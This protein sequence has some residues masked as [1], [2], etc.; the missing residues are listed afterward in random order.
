MRP[1]TATSPSSNR[2][3]ALAPF[4][5][6]YP[7]AQSVVAVFR[8]ENWPAFTQPELRTAYL[9]RPCPRLAE[10]GSLYGVADLAER[11]LRV[12]LRTI[13]GQ[14]GSRQAVDE[15][16]IGLNAALFLGTY[17][18]RC[19]L[20]DMMLYFAGFNSEF[21]PGTSYYGLADV[22]QSYARRYRPWAQQN[23]PAPPPPAEAQPAPSGTTGYAALVAYY[24][25][26][27]GRGEDVQGSALLSS[28]TFG[29]MA[30]EAMREAAE[31]ESVESDQSD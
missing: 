18:R 9:S 15:G 2:R 5:S 19:T 10:L 28:P 31:K 26:A 21:G 4:L 6:R 25:E 8:P 29:P 17:G 3:E 16:T 13:M 14:S 11:L 20:Y 24:R 12:Q 23:R 30:R 1:T 27:L 22:Q 7:S